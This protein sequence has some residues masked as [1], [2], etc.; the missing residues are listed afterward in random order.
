MWSGFTIFGNIVIQMSSLFHRFDSQCHL[1]ANGRLITKPQ[2]EDGPWDL[3]NKGLR[4]ITFEG[5][6]I[7]PEKSLT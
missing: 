5:T 1:V 4:M 2:L 7:I 3:H 6:T